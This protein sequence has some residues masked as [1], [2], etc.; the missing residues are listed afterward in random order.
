DLA[1]SDATLDTLNPGDV[2]DWSADRQL[3]VRVATATTPDGGGELRVLNDSGDWQRV[4]SWGPDDNL[5]VDGFAPDPNLLYIESNVGAN[6]SRLV[7]LNL[8]SGEQQVLAAD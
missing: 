7:T 3:R 6:A 5:D 8:G 2:D 4:Q 1:T